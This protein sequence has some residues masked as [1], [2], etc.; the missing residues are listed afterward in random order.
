MNA[1]EL[2]YD[3]KCSYVI[4]TGKKFVQYETCNSIVFTNEDQA[5]QTIAVVNGKFLMP[6]TAAVANAVGESIAVGGNKGEFYR[7]RCDINFQN[8]DGTPSLVGKCSVTEKFYLERNGY[9]FGKKN[10]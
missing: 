2:E 3:F 7:G 4:G 6:P 8:L 9:V 5:G 1:N 10:N